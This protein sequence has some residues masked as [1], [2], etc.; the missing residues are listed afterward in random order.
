MLLQSLN[1]VFPIFIIINI[2][3][4]I[5]FF[6]CFLLTNILLLFWVRRFFFV[7]HFTQVQGSCICIYIY[8]YVHIHTCGIHYCGSCSLL[9]VYQLSRGSSLHS[10][11]CVVVFSNMG[12]STCRP[13]WLNVY[14]VVDISI[15]HN[16]LKLIMFTIFPH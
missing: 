7:I 16:I 5:F 12:N 6:L 10:T 9:F 2:I 15:V 14:L 8:I 4:N 11:A 3:I 1:V 13:K